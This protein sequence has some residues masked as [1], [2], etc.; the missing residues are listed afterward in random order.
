[1]LLDLKRNNSPA[2][3]L[4]AAS[5]W[6]REWE[7]FVHI[8][9]CF[10]LMRLIFQRKISKKLKI[11]KFKF[12]HFSQFFTEF[13]E[14]SD[15]DVYST[16][17]ADFD[18][19]LNK[20][21]LSLQMKCSTTIS[22]PNASEKTPAEL[23]HQA[24]RQ[25]ERPLFSPTEPVRRDGTPYPKA[26]A[27]NGVRLEAARKR[28]EKKYSE[29]L[30]TRRCRLVVAAMEVEGRWSE[31][32]WTFLTL[33]AEVKA[34]TAPHVLKRSTQYC[35]LRRWSQMVSVAAQ[36]ALAATL[37]GETITKISPCNNLGALLTGA[38]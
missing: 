26:A 6:R 7:F 11:Q 21:Q 38:S 4:R 17:L 35:L 8:R 32:A 22:R 34:Q 1:M 23:W 2:V 9:P 10:S 19:N 5:T 36:T 14:I 31:E 37:L 15:F 24:G 25:S 30:A 20:L 29:L 3:S 33:L 27:E 18:K 28:K 13:L 12:F 16:N